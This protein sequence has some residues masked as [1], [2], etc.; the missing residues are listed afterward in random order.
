MSSVQQSRGT[1]RRARLLHAANEVGKRVASILDLDALLHETVDIICHYLS[2]SMIR[3][4][5]HCDATP[6]V[7]TRFKLLEDKGT[8]DT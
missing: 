4:G 3:N 8:L 5:T 7:L 6:I 2:L 1:E